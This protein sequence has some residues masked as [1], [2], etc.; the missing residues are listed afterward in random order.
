[1][2][3]QNLILEG[4]GIRQ[5]GLEPAWQFLIIG[6]WLCSWRSKVLII[7]QVPQSGCGGK[8]PDAMCWAQHV[9]VKAWRFQNN[10]FQLVRS[11]TVTSIFECCW[12]F[13]ALRFNATH[14]PSWAEVGGVE[15]LLEYQTMN[16]RRDVELASARPSPQQ[17]L[18]VARAL[19]WHFQL[20][21]IGP[22]PLD[23]RQILPQGWSRAADIIRVTGFRTMPAVQPNHLG[24]LGVS[25]RP[26]DHMHAPETTLTFGLKGSTSL[27]LLIAPLYF[28]FMRVWMFFH[29]FCGSATT[30]SWLHVEASQPRWHVGQ[31]II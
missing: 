21:S 4:F 29:L 14:P 11:C 5:D 22:L 26:C 17:H 24:T 27:C 1:M 3:G 25:G 30:S 18:Q 15:M 28:Q 7:H 31:V 13:L 23:F 9:S 8:S 19:K 6:Y 20:G 10:L 16:L 12:S 2:P